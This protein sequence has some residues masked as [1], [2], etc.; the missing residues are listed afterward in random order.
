MVLSETKSALVIK[1]SVEVATINF[2]RPSP[3]VRMKSFFSTVVSCQETVAFSLTVTLPSL[4]HI[5]RPGSLMNL[6]F[7]AQSAEGYEINRTSTNYAEQKKPKILSRKK[8]D[9]RY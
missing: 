8:V 5:H 2:S 6:H 3:F 9:R 1:I 7:R 4:F